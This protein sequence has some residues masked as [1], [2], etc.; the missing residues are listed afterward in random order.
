RPEQPHGLSLLDVQGHAAHRLDLTEGAREAVEIH[1][2]RLTHAARADTRT[3]PGRKIGRWAT[4][5]L[6]PRHR[7]R[8]GGAPRCE[9]C[10]CP[11][12]CA[13]CAGRWVRDRW[14]GGAA[15]VAREEK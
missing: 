10:E 11:S 1:H 12:P 8:V 3:P 13:R 5:L 9:C 2:S 6:L 4:R 7:I 15:G 14:P